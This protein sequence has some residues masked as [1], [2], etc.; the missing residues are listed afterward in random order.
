MCHELKNTCIEFQM[1]MGPYGGWVKWAA[2]GWVRPTSAFFLETSYGV[3][4]PE[5]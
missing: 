5:T 4:S 2:Q 3:P 1:Q